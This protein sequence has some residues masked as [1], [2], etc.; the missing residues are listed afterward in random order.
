[1]AKESA[2]LTSGRVCFSVIVSWKRNSTL[3]SIDIQSQLL[4]E[5]ALATDDPRLGICPR[6]GCHE[7]PSG[8]IAEHVPEDDTLPPWQR[9]TLRLGGASR[10]SPR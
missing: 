2:S 10:P 8:P 3:W 9:P 7:Y 1:M 5:G 4:G 6:N